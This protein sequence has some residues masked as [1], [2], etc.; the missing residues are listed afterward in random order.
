[1]VGG[2]LATGLVARTQQRFGRRRSFQI[3]SGRTGCCA[4]RRWWRATGLAP[5]LGCNAVALS[6]VDLHQFLVALFML[7]VG[8]NFLFTGSTTRSLAANAREEK[9][10]AQGT[11]NFCV[12]ATR[13]LSSFASGVL[14]TTQGGQLLNI[15][16]LAPVVRTGA[17]LLW[18]ARRRAAAAAAATDQVVGKRS[19]SQRPRVSNTGAVSRS[20]KIS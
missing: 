4:L 6:G 5:K 9:D 17:A 15:G 3:G 11:F 13:A 1:L 12:F 7:G 8:W 18:L 19:L 14:V 20:L 10:R 16:S 2:A